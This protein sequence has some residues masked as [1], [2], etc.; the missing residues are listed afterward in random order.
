MRTPTAQCFPIVSQH[1]G[2]KVQVVPVTYKCYPGATPQS[3]PRLCFCILGGLTLLGGSHD[4]YCVGWRYVCVWGGGYICVL[5]YIF[6]YL[7]LWTCL[8]LYIYIYMY[9][10]VCMPHSEEWMREH[11]HIARITPTLSQLTCAAI[12]VHHTTYTITS[13]PHHIHHHKCTTPHTPRHS[14]THLI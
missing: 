7:C 1:Q 13:A 10:H 8:H 6:V 5:V 9:K 2:Q 3:F 4:L 11:T 12:S 14:D